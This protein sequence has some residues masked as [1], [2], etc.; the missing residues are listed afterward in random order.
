MR[1]PRILV[2][3]LI[4]FIAVITIAVWWL[5]FQPRRRAKA[6]AATKQAGGVIQLDGEFW[7]Q[8]QPKPSPVVDLTRLADK[9]ISFLPPLCA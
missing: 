5:S 1:R 4:V 9:W 6:I 8:W 2:R 7:P 3:T